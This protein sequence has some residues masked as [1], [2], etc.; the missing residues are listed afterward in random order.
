MKRLDA[1]MFIYVSIDTRPKPFLSCRFELPKVRIPE[2][3][4]VAWQILTIG[5]SVARFALG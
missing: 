5:L 3:V 4:K 2:R 1:S